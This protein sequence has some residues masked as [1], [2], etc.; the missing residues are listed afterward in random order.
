L[1]AGSPRSHAPCRVFV[2]SAPGAPPSTWDLVTLEGEGGYAGRTALIWTNQADP[3]C[4]CSESDT[5]CV[6]DVRGVVIAGELPPIP[7]ATD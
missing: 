3:E 1:I 7:E 5:P 6:W 4:D 2:T